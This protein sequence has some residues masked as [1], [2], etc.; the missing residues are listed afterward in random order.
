LEEKPAAGGG[1]GGGRVR[2]FL[3]GSPYRGIEYGFVVMRL[4]IAYAWLAAI[5]LAF[6]NRWTSLLAGTLN[7]ANLVKGLPQLGIFGTQNAVTLYLFATTL[8]TLGAI[9]FIIGL[10]VRLVALWGIIEFFINATTGQLINP[11]SLQK[12]FALFGASLLLF[13]HGSHA[14]SIDG[15]LMRSRG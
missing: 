2:S 5:F 10:G 14:L 9:L 4:V 15:R 7:G 3:F 13:I 8:E 6:G 1:G 11:L 12:D